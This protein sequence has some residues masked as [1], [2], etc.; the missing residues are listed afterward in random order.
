MNV[1]AGGILPAPSAMRWT[2]G[3]PTAGVSRPGRTLRRR[4]G[5]AT[6][7]NTADKRDAGS[8]TPRAPI[9]SAARTT[10]GAP[11]S[12]TTPDAMRSLRAGVP[13]GNLPGPPHVHRVRW[14]AALRAPILRPR[15]LS[16]SWLPSLSCSMRLSETSSSMMKGAQPACQRLAA[17]VIASLWLFCHNDADIHGKYP[18]G[19]ASHS[20][21]VEKTVRSRRRV[22]REGY[23]PRCVP[24]GVRAAESGIS[25][26]ICEA[27][28]RVFS[29]GGFRS[30]SRFR[31]LM[32]ADRQSGRPVR[33]QETS[34]N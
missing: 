8:T 20:G 11:Q 28:I 18:I 3:G 5:S 22:H 6:R 13:P 25:G 29:T 1:G 9:R 31:G 32:R 34:P 7:R 15:V 21:I 30:L 24:E 4:A 23:N 16:V 17:Q 14:Q 12:R 26:R 27:S 10:G 33:R 2:K 19:G